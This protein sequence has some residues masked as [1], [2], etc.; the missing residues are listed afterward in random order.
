MF[1]Q[2]TSFLEGKA[3]RLGSGRIAEC[4]TSPYEIAAHQKSSFGGRVGHYVDFYQEN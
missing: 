1:V 3:L 4:S 2:I